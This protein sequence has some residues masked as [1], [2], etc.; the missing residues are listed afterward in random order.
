MLFGLENRIKSGK[1][2]RFN[3]FMKFSNV[4]HLSLV[5]TWF[6]ISVLEEP[7]FFEVFV[8]ID[9]D[10]APN[11]RRLQTQFLKSPCSLHVLSPLDTFSRRNHSVLRTL[12][13]G[14]LVDSTMAS[15]F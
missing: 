2:C 5:L 4:S 6:I 13:E 7:L 8:V 12:F 11:T 14:A 9:R 10:P 1:H 3:S 15:F